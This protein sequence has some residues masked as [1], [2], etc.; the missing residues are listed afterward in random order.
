ME[1]FFLNQWYKLPKISP[2]APRKRANFN[3]SH[4]WLKKSAEFGCL[5]LL[6]QENRVTGLILLLQD[7][8][9]HLK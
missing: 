8:E 1:C 7:A 9:N 5:I 6:V 4:G 3:E 2:A